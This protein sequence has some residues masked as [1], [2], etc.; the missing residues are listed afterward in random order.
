MHLI[1]VNIGQEQAIARAKS[2]GKTGIY[3]L[4]HN[5]P[6]EITPLG[7]PGD[8]IIDTE[9]HGGVDQAVYLYGASDYAWWSRE[10][11]QELLPGTFGENLTLSELESAT[12][13]V[14]DR[15]QI[16]AVIL[17]VTAPR[18]PCSTLAARMNDPQFVKRFRA[19]ERP[20]LY[21]RVLQAGWVEAG[22]PVTYSRY[23]GETISI[24]EMFRNFYEPRH[25]I[26]TL[27]RYLVA[28]TPLRG[29]AEKEAELRDLLKQNKI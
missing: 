13:L 21:C 20:G 12:A 15:L 14:G 23:T 11:G 18:I 8:V 5:G 25:D 24:L 26:E 2:S 22:S 4:P 17:E 1:S 29:R 16:G 28:P 27:R 10:L 9:N 7:I 3:K 6:V 19:A